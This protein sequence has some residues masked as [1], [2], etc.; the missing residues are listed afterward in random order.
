MAVA[1][2]VST[3][4]DPDT[5]W[6]TDSRSNKARAARRHPWERIRFYGLCVATV[7]E[8][9]FQVHEAAEIGLTKLDR[10]DWYYTGLQGPR[11]LQIAGLVAW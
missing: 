1:V 6:W 10:E 11:M 8:V 9:G 7:L 2:N 5:S 3:S 4:Q